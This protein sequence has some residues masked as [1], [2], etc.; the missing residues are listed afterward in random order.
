MKYAPVVI[1]D[2]RKIGKYHI[3]IP[4]RENAIRKPKSILLSRLDGKILFWNPNLLNKY[5]IAKILS[6][7]NN[8][9][10]KVSENKELPIGFEVSWKGIGMPW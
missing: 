1:K 9:W 6:T 5:E 3:N 2:I 7:I 4:D 8:I 10:K